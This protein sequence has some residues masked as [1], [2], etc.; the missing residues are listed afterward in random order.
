MC[1]RKPASFIEKLKAGKDYLSDPE[2]ARSLDENEFF[3]VPRQNPTDIFSSGGD[4]SVGMKDGV[5]Y[6]VRF[7]GAGMTL[8]NDANEKKGA[9]SSKDA[10]HSNFER[11]MFVTARFNPDLIPKPELE[12]LPT[13]KKPEEKKPGATKPGAT[14]PE[15]GKP[16]EKKPAADKST[17]NKPEA[18]KPDDKPA[19]LKAPEKKSTDEKAATPKTDD[20]TTEKKP[21]EKPG[22][23]PA[24]ST[25]GK[26]TSS[27]LS[28]E[29]LALA[30]TADDAKKLDDA[31]TSDD[32]KNAKET[33]PAPAAK[34][35]AEDKT[36]EDKTADKAAGKT[37]PDTKSESKKA[38][39][40][41]P[42]ETTP[43]G[44]K[45]GET[46]PDAGKPAADK[47]KND[48]QRADEEAA[49]DAE[50]KR[51]ETE[52][53][54]KQDQYDET[55]KKGKA[56]AKELNNRFADWY[57][58]ISEDE[59]KKVHVGLNDIVK[60]KA[61]TESASGLQGQV[62]ADPFNKGGLNLP[63]P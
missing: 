57:Y 63:H 10:K 58:M 3:G 17:E 50:K 21:V 2:A 41:K 56:H 38:D 8:K 59:Y 14:T 1:M 37:P 54:R 6:T 49:L 28:G 23:K 5:E 32:S 33:K 12:P 16:E 9:G 35:P 55:I 52:N 34:T 53:R 61:G 42:P 40:K 15:A 51:V 18:K 11:V 36:A 44:K 25:K 48:T 24:D 47:P 26:Q 27:R 13:A 45:I 22:D 43:A 31:K 46:K 20:G 60:K 30:D 19:E 62:P 39:E 4:L 29:L 7:G